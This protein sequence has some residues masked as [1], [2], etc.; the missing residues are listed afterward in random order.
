MSCQLESDELVVAGLMNLWSQASELICLN[1]THLTLVLP[2]R[3]MP[4]VTATAATRWDRTAA[5]VDR[6]IEATRAA[7]RSILPRDSPT[8]RV[9]AE[10]P[11]GA[12]KN[13]ASRTRQRAHGSGAG[14]HARDALSRL[15]IGASQV[16]IALFPKMRR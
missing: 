12:A 11:A 8:A 6:E 15:P 16:T 7:L 14:P 9:D 4:I 5:G 10:S 3:L 2:D 13:S 1:N